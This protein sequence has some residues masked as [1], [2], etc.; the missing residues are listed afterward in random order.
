MKKNESES[1]FGKRGLRK[2]G[3]FCRLSRRQEPRAGRMYS[4]MLFVKNVS[5]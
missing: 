4:G 3:F 1:S 2:S 5:D